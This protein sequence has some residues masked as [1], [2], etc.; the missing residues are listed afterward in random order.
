MIERYEVL[1]SPWG[2]TPCTHPVEVV[3]AM[4]R[5]PKA[6]RWC[7]YSYPFGYPADAVG[8]FIE[9]RSCR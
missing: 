8:S 4:D 1:W 2:I 9:V 3:A 6:D 5:M 7:G